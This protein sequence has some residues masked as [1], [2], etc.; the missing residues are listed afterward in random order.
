MNKTNCKVIL[1]NTGNTANILRY[2]FFIHSSTNKH[3]LFPIL[4][5]LTQGYKYIFDLVF[6]FSSDKHPKV[7]LL[8]YMIVLFFFFTSS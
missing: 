3:R 1:C 5:Q 8:D 2:I 6:L 4:L 7:E